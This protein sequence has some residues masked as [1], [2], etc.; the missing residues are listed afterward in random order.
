MLTA[1][2]TRRRDAGALLGLRWVCVV[3][4]F[5]PVPKNVMISMLL[6]G[7]LGLLGFHTSFTRA[8]GEYYP[9]CH[10]ADKGSWEG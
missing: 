2:M 3:C 4:W 6:L 5:V 1:R 8:R 10:I 9:G 7:L